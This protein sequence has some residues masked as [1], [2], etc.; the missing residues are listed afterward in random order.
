MDEQPNELSN[1]ENEDEIEEQLQRRDALDLICSGR[2][3]FRWRAS[4]VSSPTV[5]LAGLIVAITGTVAAVAV[6]AACAGP[7]HRRLD[8]ALE[9][10]LI[11]RLIRCDRWRT[12]AAVLALAGAA[13]AAVG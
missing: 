11:R 6:T 10:A 4:R 13:L 1:R 5:Q 7:T 3:L 8:A 12:I 2:C 9:P